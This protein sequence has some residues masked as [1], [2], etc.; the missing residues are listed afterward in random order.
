M[1]LPKSSFLC[2]KNPK[3]PYTLHLLAFETKITHLPLL[4]KDTGSFFIMTFSFVRCLPSHPN[5]YDRIRCFGEQLLRRQTLTSA[6]PP[7]SPASRF[8]ASWRA[9]NA[10]P[11]TTAPHSTTSSLGPFRQ[12]TDAIPT[13][14]RL[15]HMAP[16]TQR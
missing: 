5:L 4:K 9:T 8:R 13:A 12:A 16:P 10:A 2:N 15:S 3:T 11:T 14:D 6:L 1:I 7:L